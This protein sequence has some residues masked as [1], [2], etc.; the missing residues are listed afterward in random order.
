MSAKT[1][2]S[3]LMLAAQAISAGPID[4]VRLKYG[5]GGDWYN[6]PEAEI[7]LLL[8]FNRRT[9][10][11][12]R[13][14]K[15]AL[16][17]LDEQLFSH[18]FLFI[19]GHG[20]IRFTDQEIQRLRRHLV[21]GGFLYADDDYG[22]DASFRRQMKRLFPDQEL[23]ELPPDFPLFRCFYDLSSGIPK[24]HEHEP[25]RP[26]ARGIFH[27]GRL[28]VLYTHNTNISDGWTPAHGDAEET[29]EQAFR[30]GVNILWYVL[31][32]Q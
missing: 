17:L 16:S 22:M 5:G 15:T 27:R 13:A 29:R 2:I 11:A 8:E 28:V 18:P 12:V 10:A 21:S 1:L 32:R 3:A 23:A 6:D 4:I 26:S 7:N 31:T 24:I 14:E 25:G 19:T 9:G 30:M 20:E